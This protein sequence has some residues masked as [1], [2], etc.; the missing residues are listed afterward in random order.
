MDWSRA[1]TILIVVFLAIDIFLGYVILSESSGSA[2]HVDSESLARITAYLADK[3]VDVKGSIPDRKKEMASINV[4]YKLFRKDAVMAALFPEGGNVTETIG[5]NTVSLQAAAIRAEIKDNRELTY[6]DSSIRPS[7]VIDEK[8]CSRK[9]GEFLASLGI[10]DDADTR[11][12][13]NAG[14]YLRMVYN[15]TFNGAQIY[16]SHMEFYVNNSGIHKARIVWFETVRQVG[17]KMDV[18]SPAIAL[19]HVTKHNKD[20]LLPSREVLEVQQGYYF[21]TGVNEQVD[22]SIVEEGTAF[23]VWK[24][25]TDRDILYINAYNEKIEGIEKAGK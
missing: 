1:K 17:K 10:K 21:G 5:I 19:L 20:N 24:I 13:E 8:N 23:P 25:V 3:G 7:E 18:I 12:V 16:N 6:T 22:A 15:Q 2:G 11:R 4:K 14:G 9:V